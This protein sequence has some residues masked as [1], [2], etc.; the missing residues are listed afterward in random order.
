MLALQVSIVSIVFSFGLRS[1][2]HDLLFLW[3][4]PGLLLRSLLAVLVVMPVLAVLLTRLFDLRDTVETTLV[5]LAISPMPPL[6]PKKEIQAGGRRSVRAG[7]VGDDGDSRRR[8]LSVG[9]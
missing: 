5:A 3:R 6:L 4:R 8:R 1:T 9:G 2:L 7:A